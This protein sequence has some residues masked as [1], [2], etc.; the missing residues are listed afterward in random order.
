MGSSCTCLYLP[1]PIG[2]RK[3]D[4]VASL[5]ALILLS[6]LFFVRLAIAQAGVAGSGPF[7]AGTD[8]LYAPRLHTLQ[9]P[10]N[11]GPFGCRSLRPVKDFSLTSLGDLFI[12]YHNFPVFSFFSTLFHWC[13]GLVVGQ[14]LQRHKLYVYEQTLITS[15]SPR[16]PSSNQS[17]PNPP[18][19]FS[20]NIFLLLHLEVVLP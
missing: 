14:N 3:L 15:S 17:F 9:V 4:L 11:G 10:N 16:P 20:S 13:G 5:T 1:V 2:K 7:Q 12:G 6:H 8:R 18:T 19:P